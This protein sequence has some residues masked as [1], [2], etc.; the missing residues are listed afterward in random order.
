MIIAAAIVVVW[1]VLLGRRTTVTIMN[2][3]NDKLITITL[4]CNEVMQRRAVNTGLLLHAALRHELLGVSVCAKPRW[5]IA[6]RNARNGTAEVGNTCILS[7]DAGDY[8]EASP[9]KEPD[10]SF[11]TACC[12]SIHT[13]ETITV[14]TGTTTRS[15]NMKAKLMT[16]AIQQQ[17]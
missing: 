2:K 3:N 12:F 5:P 4:L 9:T 13:T 7:Q 16:I 14:K 15:K 8:T 11:R 1:I 17:P 6:A 10:M